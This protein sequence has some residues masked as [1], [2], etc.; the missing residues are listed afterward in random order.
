MKSFYLSC[1]MLVLL[2][3]VCTSSPL[4]NLDEDDYESELNK[5]VTAVITYT[6]YA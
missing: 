1:F 6:K 5:E 2:L 3:S 4:A